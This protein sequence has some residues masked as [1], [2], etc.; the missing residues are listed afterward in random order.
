MA[1]DSQNAS[2]KAEAPNSCAGCGLPNAVD[3]KHPARH[4]TTFGVTEVKDRAVIY[5][6]QICQTLTRVNGQ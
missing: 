3:E 5:E 4:E 2:V 6:C 1:S